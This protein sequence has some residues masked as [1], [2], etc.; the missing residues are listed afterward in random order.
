MTPL[1]IRR[2]VLIPAALMLTAAAPLTPP[3]MALTDALQPHR[4]VYAIG[5]ASTSKGS[6]VTS[7]E[8]Q[9]VFELTGSVCAG[10]TMRQRLIVDLG[11]E[12]GTNGKLDFRIATFESGDGD[13][14]RF[15]SRTRMNDQ[16]VDD[17][18]GEAKR[19][20]SD[21]EVSLKQP[22]PST[23]K[24]SAG[25]LFPSQ[26]LQAILN[27]ARADQ[28]VVSAAIYEASG[29][30]NAVDDALAAI[31]AG[32]QGTPGT[33]VTSGKRSWPVS[34]GYFSDLPA[35]PVVAGEETPTYQMSF[36]LYDN[37]VT[38][39][40]VMDYGKYALSGTLTKIEPL[41]ATSCQ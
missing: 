6:G 37:G 16:V 41:P 21:V 34:V 7:A 8:G 26:H 11:D 4:A 36:R 15:D 24:L 35:Q 12:D 19:S 18:E 31:G 3:P 32:A 39:D 9:M 40:L 10:Y 22:A 25:T 29:T 13:V 2:L 30:G 17:I 33:E 14:F 28:H 20:A 23:V 5:L 27:A 1:R 38:N